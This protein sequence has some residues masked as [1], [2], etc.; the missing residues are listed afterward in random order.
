MVMSVILSLNIGLGLLS[1]AAVNS[2][3]SMPSR[4]RCDA[5]A[6]GTYDV[7][8]Q[9]ILVAEPID[10]TQPTWPARRSG[11]GAFAC[12]FPVP[13]A[14]RVSEMINDPVRP[15]N[16][17]VAIH[18]QMDRVWPGAAVSEDT[19]QVHISAI[20]K[21]LGQDRAMLQ[22][23]SGRGYRLLCRW[24]IKD[25]AVNMPPSGLTLAQET[26]EPVRSNLPTATADLIGRSAEVSQIQTL[27]SAY[28]IVTLTGPG[29]IGKTALA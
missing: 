16:E 7:S 5:A 10:V 25:M 23:V 26:V 12:R 24:T 2:V 18:D 3:I 14:T 1:A 29:R 17:L 9:T 19:I 27:L 15:A 20:R 4:K 21:A 13:I 28:R 11:I 8:I 6:V 22:M